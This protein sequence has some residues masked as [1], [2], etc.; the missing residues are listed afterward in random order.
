MHALGEN[1]NND[2]TENAQRGP[3]HHVTKVSCAPVFIQA[4]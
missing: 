2:Q 1:G 4:R 3:F